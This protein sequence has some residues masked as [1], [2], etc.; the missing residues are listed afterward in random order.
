MAKHIEE[1]PHLLFSQREGLIPIPGPLKL[2]ARS[3]D[4]RREGFS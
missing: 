1:F 3:D 4:L 2:G